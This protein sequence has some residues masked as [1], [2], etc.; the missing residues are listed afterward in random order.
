MTSKIST[1]IRM[2]VFEW[3]LHLRMVHFPFIYW[4]SYNHTLFSWREIWGVRCILALSATQNNHRGYNLP[5]LNG[6]Y[7]KRKKV[8][9]RPN[10]THIIG[11]GKWKVAKIVLTLIDIVKKL[12]SK[13]GIFLLSCH[14]RKI[15]PNI[16]CRS[17]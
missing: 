1:S 10:N 16:A 14:I 6:H 9:D 7:L 13:H 11:N 4:N 15:L 17:N 3:V 8:K 12:P 2:L 5:Q